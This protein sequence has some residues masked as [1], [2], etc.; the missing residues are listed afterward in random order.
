M[1]AVDPIQTRRPESQF[2]VTSLGLMHKVREFERGPAG[3]E[4]GELEFLARKIVG[5]ICFVGLIVVMIIEAL[6]RGFFVV[7][8]E[9]LDSLGALLSHRVEPGTPE[10]EDA[11]SERTPLQSTD[12]NS[13]SRTKSSVDDLPDA[14]ITQDARVRQS[15]TGNILHLAGVQYDARRP[16]S[17]A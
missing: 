9:V 3:R 8:A 16:A 4:V 11:A 1:S 2:F 14:H 5:E 12:N 15:V 13:S 17:P 7:I 10:Q 6:V